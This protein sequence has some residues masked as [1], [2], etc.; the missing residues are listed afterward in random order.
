MSKLISISISIIILMQSFGIQINDISQ[1]DEF[2]EHAQFHNEEYGDN[3]IV[4]IA[5]HYGELKAEH[6]QDHQEEKEEHEEL[7]FQ[8]QSQLTSITAIVFNTQRSELKLLEPL[9]YKK[10]NFFYQHHLHHCIVMDY[11]SRLSF[12]KYPC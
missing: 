9:E 11:S 10:H 3:I 5:K 12:H 7:P 1:I 2:I 8:Q 4:F 6:A